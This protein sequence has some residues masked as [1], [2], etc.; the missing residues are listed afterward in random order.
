[1]GFPSQFRGKSFSYPE[2]RR[3]WWRLKTRQVTQKELQ[4]FPP[5]DQTSM[6]TSVCF[7]LCAHHSTCLRG[8]H[9]YCIRKL[10]ILVGISFLVF[11]KT[12]VGP[13]ESSWASRADRAADS[14]HATTS[15]L[16]TISL[17]AVITFGS[18]VGT[19]GNKMQRLKEWARKLKPKSGDQPSG[20]TN[21]KENV[22]ISSAHQE[23]PDNSSSQREAA[24][25]SSNAPGQNGSS[26]DHHRS[27]C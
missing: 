6:T 11:L 7:L 16:R 20:A 8:T 19:M 3:R 25:I 18:P 22:V 15:P 27:Q 23:D 17:R 14:L 2:S 9:C 13:G 10:V 5:P 1:V 12:L 4:W 21:P 24:A 26:A